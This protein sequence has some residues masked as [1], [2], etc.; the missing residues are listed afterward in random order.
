MKKKLI[1]FFYKQNILNIYIHTQL[2][3]EFSY[4]IY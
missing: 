1:K 3:N 4:M 2:P